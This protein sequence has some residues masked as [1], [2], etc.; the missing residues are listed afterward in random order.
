M[1]PLVSLVLSSGGA[2]G[3]AHIGVIEELEHQGYNIC[4]ISGSSMGAMVGGVYASGKLT[5]FRDRMCNL[6]KIEL[7]N[8]LD[9]TIS[10]NGLVK[11]DKI[12]K[13]LR[14]I[15]PDEMIE[16]LPIHY[17][18]VATDINNKKEVIF[19]KGS[20]FDAIR[21]SISIPTIFKPY[22]Q[23]GMLLIDG[24]VVNPLPINRVKRRSNDI[25]IA[26][27]V[28]APIED[29][30]IQKPENKE[31]HENN[32]RQLFYP[33]KREFRTFSK[34][35][36]EK[37][38][39][40]SLL[41]QTGSIMMQKITAMSIAHYQPDILI[42]IPVNTCSAYQFYMSEKIIEKGRLAT[43]DA[44]KKFELRMGN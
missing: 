30:V 8:M 24:G 16:N 38:N 15:V 34:T 40:Y 29:V 25:L 9:F 36:S 22:I 6:D 17:A 41:S 27:D 32:F 13:E 1:K 7:F 21:A 35:S 5:V 4:S 26:V 20:L 10:T 42:Q 44:L 3:V 14:K 11:G 37:L 12:F 2:R 43:Q 28:S 19:D 39:Y 23:N 33:L 31:K 18:A